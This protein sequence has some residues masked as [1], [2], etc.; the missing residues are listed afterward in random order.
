MVE[1]T[2]DGKIKL[3]LKGDKDTA[4]EG[5]YKVDGDAFTTHEGGDDEHTQTLRSSS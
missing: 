3:D 5:T 1:F 4:M 2:K